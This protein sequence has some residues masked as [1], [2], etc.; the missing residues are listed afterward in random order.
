MRKIALINHVASAK[1]MVE[2][3]ANLFPI[4]LKLLN[5]IPYGERLG[6]DCVA[7]IVFLTVVL[8]LCLYGERGIGVFRWMNRP[9]FQYNSATASCLFC[10]RTDNP[11][12]DFKN[13]PIVTTRLIV[14]NKEREVCI[15]CY[16]ELREA[17]Q[18]SNKS[19]PVI[20][21][22]KLNLVRIFEKQK[23]SIISTS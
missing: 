4:C 14:K 7:M 3:L 21:E 12:P 5:G 10:E 9:K 15:N 2:S 13:E 1:T 16:Y 20:L 18:S 8:V 11:H 17:A 19:F 23:N 6:T 22:E